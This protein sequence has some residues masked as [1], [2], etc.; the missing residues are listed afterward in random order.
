MPLINFWQAAGLVI[1][2]RLLF[3]FGHH[4]NRR[5]WSGPQ[6]NSDLRNKIKN[7]SPEEKKEFY[8][9]MHYKSDNLHRG[10]YSEKEHDP[11][12]KSEE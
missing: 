8:R 4:S 7:M 11:V 6:I 5:K 12:E 1:L 10:C 9:K 2:T 3:G